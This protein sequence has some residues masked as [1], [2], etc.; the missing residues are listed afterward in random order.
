MGIQTIPIRITF[1]EVIV[2]WMN[3]S[4][5]KHQKRNLE[6]LHTLSQQPLMNTQEKLSNK[7]LFTM[8]QTELQTR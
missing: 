2:L 3:L 4:A 5:L 1:S 8:S 7:N 6:I